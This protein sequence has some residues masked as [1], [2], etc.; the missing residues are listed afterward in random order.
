M[1][2]QI[3]DS[4]KNFSATEWS[5]T[6]TCFIELAVILFYN[7]GTMLCKDKLSAYED[8]LREV[9]KNLE[10]ANNQITILKGGDSDE[11]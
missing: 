2:Q 5:L 9:K 7:K 4:I 3:I 1:F 10:I 8:E 11:D 6:I